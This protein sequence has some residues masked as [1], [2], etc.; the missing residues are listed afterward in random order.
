MSFVQCGMHGA[1]V[2]IECS[3]QYCDNATS[4]RRITPQRADGCLHEN[5]VQCALSTGLGRTI[6][7]HEI[8]ADL[9]KS[10]M[11]A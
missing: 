8:N 11:Y 1:V 9:M 3:Q 2:Y 10:H 6:S 5:A 7:A 4:V